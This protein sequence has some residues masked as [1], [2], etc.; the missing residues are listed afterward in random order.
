MV[1]TGLSLSLW[2]GLFQNL[3]LLLPLFKRRRQRDFGL[4]LWGSVEHR[5]NPTPP[6]IEAPRRSCEAGSSLSQLHAIT[7]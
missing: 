1:G 3:L 6:R 2:W 4:R 5:R 7:A